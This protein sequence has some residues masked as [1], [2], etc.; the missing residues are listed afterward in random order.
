[1]QLCRREAGNIALGPFL[2]SSGRRFREDFRAEIG[3]SPK[4]WARLERFAATIHQLHPSGWG[5]R[6]GLPLPDHYDQAHAIREFQEHAGITPGAYR[7][8]KAAGDPRLFVL[9][10][11]G[12]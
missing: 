11:Y 9:P 4:R 7:A 3:C 6:D 2:G 1:M 5:D 12:P 10:E 8:I